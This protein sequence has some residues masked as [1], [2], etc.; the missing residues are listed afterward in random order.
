MRNSF[1]EN[2]GVIILLEGI[3]YSRKLIL[4][5]FWRYMKNSTYITSVIVFVGICFCFAPFNGFSFGLFNFY[6]GAVIL[7]LVLY[8]FLSIII[9]EYVVRYFINKNKKIIYLRNCL[10]SVMR[11]VDKTDGKN[12]IREFVSLFNCLDNF[13]CI[14]SIY[15]DNCIRCERVTAKDFLNSMDT[16]DSLLSLFD[17]KKLS[18]KDKKRV[19]RLYKDLYNVSYY[20][21]LLKEYYSNNII[22][23]NKNLLNNMFSLILS[24]SGLAISIFAM[25]STNSNINIWYRICLV[26]VLILTD[27]ITTPFL[28]R[29]FRNLE[30]KSLNYKIKLSKSFILFDKSQEFIKIKNKI[31]SYSSQNDFEYIKTFFDAELKRQHILE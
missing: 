22:C 2:I 20:D 19:K 11:M 14:Y 4:M 27:F 12:N 8:L 5:I 16:I 31:I 28:Y 24:I 7:S 9:D 21:N 23:S 6:D 18:Y 15:Y 1:I 17:C 3:C 10:F 26:L 13:V 29:D 25:V 30:I